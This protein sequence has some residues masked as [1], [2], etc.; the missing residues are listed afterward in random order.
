M[1]VS[2]RIFAMLLMSVSCLMY[3]GCGDSADPTPS[4]TTSATDGSAESGGSETKSEGGGG[5][6]SK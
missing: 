3:V 6:N 1:R 2:F 5:S 4:D